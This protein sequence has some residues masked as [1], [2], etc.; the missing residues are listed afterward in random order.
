MLHAP[1]N[2]DAYGLSQV[3]YSIWTRLSTRTAHGR[4]PLLCAAAL[5]FPKRKIYTSGI[6]FAP[7]PL[8]P[9]PYAA[10][11]V[12]SPVRD[13]RVLSGHNIIAFCCWRENAAG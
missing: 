10:E 3:F 6:V 2:L 5:A 9:T 11:R 7:T 12:S 4:P 8:S 1:S 13:F